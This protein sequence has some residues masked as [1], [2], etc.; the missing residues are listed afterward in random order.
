MKLVVKMRY[1]EYFRVIGFQQAGGILLA[2]ALSIQ[3][4]VCF[5][6]HFISPCLSAIAKL[7]MSNL[8]IL[9]VY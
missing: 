2:R 4:H 7:P 1:R 3:K 6:R 5:L 9:R 8:F